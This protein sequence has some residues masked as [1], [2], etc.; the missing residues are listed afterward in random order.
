MLE[1]VFSESAAGSIAFAISQATHAPARP[2]GIGIIEG[3]HLSRFKL[4]RRYFKA[5]RRQQRQFAQ[6]VPIQNTR[7]NI[8]CL[9]LYLSIGS[10]AE[11]YIGRKRQA[12]LQ[13]LMQTY[14]DAHDVTQQLLETGRSALARILNAVCAGESL[15]I[16]CSDNPDEASGMY[17]L[18]W[19]LCRAGL[20]RAGIT[21]AALPRF[22]QWDSTSQTL[23]QYCGWGDVAPWHWGR[24]AQSAY[25]ITPMHLKA[26]ASVWEQLRTQ[27]APLRA[28]VNAKLVS[29]PETLYDSFLLREIDAQPDRFHQARLIGNVLGKYGLGIS[30]AWLALRIQHMIDR[31]MLKICSHPRQGDP[32]YHRILE[33]CASFPSVKTPYCAEKKERP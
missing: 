23:M 10:I 29:M 18:A 15:R 32:A 17:W 13:M 22:I 31:G 8:V 27:D 4:H 14:P 9:P 6:S 11:S 28:V 21:L 33:K 19:Q 25:A 20:S 2:A 3:A 30:D 12:A 24:L 7:Q 16:F 26:M 5:L 1:V